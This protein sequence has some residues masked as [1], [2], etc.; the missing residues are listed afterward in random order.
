VLENIE[1][2][3]R[4]QDLAFVDVVSDLSKA[5]KTSIHSKIVK[6]ISKH[7][8]QLVRYSMEKVTV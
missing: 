2:L 5:K 7:L 6:P 1:F 4:V 3:S 8:A